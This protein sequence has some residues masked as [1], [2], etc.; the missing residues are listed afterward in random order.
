MSE[1]KKRLTEN[2]Q[3]K[4][5]KYSCLDRNLVFTL[6]TGKLTADQFDEIIKDNDISILVDVRSKPRGWNRGLWGSSL[7]KRYGK[8]YHWLGNRLGGFDIDEN[9]GSSNWEK[10]ILELIELS[11]KGRL[12][13]FC[14]EG[15]PERCH[16]SRIAN[17]LREHCL[18]ARGD[19]VG[20]VRFQE[21][22]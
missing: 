5:E 7:V 10:G 17:E 12:A 18:R 3:L 8:R 1:S 19:L 20:D 13:I 11:L 4:I 21:Q 6:G 2:S 16:R 9:Y 14:A 15:D 22:A